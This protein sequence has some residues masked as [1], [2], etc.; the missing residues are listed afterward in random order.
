MK[1]IPIL[2]ICGSEGLFRRNRFDV[3][4]RFASSNQSH[5]SNCPSKYL[6]P[7]LRLNPLPPP[8]SCPPLVRVRPIQLQLLAQTLILQEIQ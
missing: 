1:R 7:S 4:L 2:E 3:I 8:L 6:T 5:M